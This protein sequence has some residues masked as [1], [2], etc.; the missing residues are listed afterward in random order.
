MIKRNFFMII[1]IVIGL[2]LAACGDSSENT[3]AE[4]D[5]STDATSDS[6]AKSVL[7]MGSS[8][9][10]G[11]Y[12]T[13]AVALSQTINEFVDEI[14]TRAEPTGG[15]VHNIRLMQSG[16]AELGIVSADTMYDALNGEGDFEGQAHEDMSIIVSGH[17]SYTQI[18]APENSSIESI[19]DL[20]GK[21][22]AWRLQGSSTVENMG[23]A[24]FA[25]YG[26]DPD[27]DF[28]S[29]I[30][31]PYEDAA[32]RMRDGRTDS[33]ITFPGIPAPWMI[34]YLTGD[35]MKLISI[36]EDKLDNILEKY[37]FYL[38]DVIPA[39]T[40]DGIDYDVTTVGFKAM[41]VA[42]NDVSEDVVYEITKALL[43][44]K[45]YALSVADSIEPYVD[46][47]NV[48]SV[49]GVGEYHPG[50]IKYYKEIGIWD[51]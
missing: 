3:D 47:D 4:D 27:E 48:T 42:N 6:G 25:E 32:Q 44:N 49:Q 19:A 8:A 17:T 21:R 46:E 34:E 5:N 7:P 18:T 13:N 20:E 12:H 40:Y 11:L 9:E 31:S 39:G 30:A 37:P 2:T 29:E 43:E 16:E 50:A 1:F 36:D 41:L 22:V 35:P 33:V 26:L 14:D 28:T 45:D 38:K 15:S 23:R 24:V 10:G 51:E